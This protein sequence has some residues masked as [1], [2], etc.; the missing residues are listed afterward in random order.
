MQYGSNNLIEIKIDGHSSVAQSILECVA[1]MF[2]SKKKTK[3]L[4]FVIAKMVSQMTITKWEALVFKTKE[5]AAFIF[6]QI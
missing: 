3:H 6:T 2:L 4:M 5:D 1:G